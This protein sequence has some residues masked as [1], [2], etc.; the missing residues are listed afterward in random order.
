MKFGHT[1]GI[2]VLA[3]NCQVCGIPEA[4]DLVFIHLDIPIRPVKRGKGLVTSFDHESFPLSC[5]SS[6]ERLPK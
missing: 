6:G 5:D 1:F 3:D 4:T 2:A